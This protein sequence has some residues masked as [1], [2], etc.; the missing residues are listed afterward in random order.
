MK[1]VIPQ[2]KVALKIQDALFIPREI[3]V[4]QLQYKD[5]EVK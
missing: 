3:T 4:Q 2:S 1:E 5:G